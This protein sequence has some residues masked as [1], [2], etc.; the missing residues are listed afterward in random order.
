MVLMFKLVLFILDELIIV[1]DVIVE[2][3]VVEL[4]KDLGKKYGI[5]MLFIL[6][7]F[8]LVLEICD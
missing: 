8:G 6:Y 3:V 2:V 1:F 5:L 4:V 7:N